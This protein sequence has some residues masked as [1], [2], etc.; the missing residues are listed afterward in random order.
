MVAR[1][2]W[3]R[4][5]EPDLKDALGQR[6]RAGGVH[7]RYYLRVLRLDHVAGA[8]LV[9]HYLWS[10]VSDRRNAGIVCIHDRPG[11]RA[12]QVASAQRLRDQTTLARPGQYDVRLDGS[13]GVPFVFTI[14][15]YLGGQPAG[16]ESMV[17]AASPR[18]LGMGG[19]GH[20]DFPF[21]DALRSIAD[22]QGQTQ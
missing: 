18:R 10:N 3:D 21:C 17:S 9:L 19:P 7:V 11:H 22:A 5:R 12:I 13:V 15:Y 20:R 16:R 6:T 4:R 2:G 1:A 14:Y 8:E